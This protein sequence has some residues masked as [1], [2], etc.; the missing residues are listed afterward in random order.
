MAHRGTR[1]KCPNRVNLHI[2]VQYIPVF[3][4]LWLHTAIF[5][6][7]GKQKYLDFAFAGIDLVK[8]FEITT[9]VLEMTT[10]EIEVK[11]AKIM[12]NIV[13][14]MYHSRTLNIFFQM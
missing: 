8:R 11:L 13:K 10:S 3:L 4:K 1:L 7:T 6:V 5:A 2:Y 14:I 9:S 12:G